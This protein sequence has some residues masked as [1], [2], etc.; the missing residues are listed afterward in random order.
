MDLTE[1]VK[2]NVDLLREV[3]TD[4]AKPGVKQ[5]GRS[6]DAI[7]GLGNTVLWPILLVN[8]KSRMALENNLEKYRK[9][10]ES[11][12]EEKVVRVS[13]E[14]GVPIAEK[15]SYVEDPDLSEMYLELL[16]KASKS[17]SANQ[18]HPSFVNTINNL[19]P[20]EALILD[21]IKD[22]KDIPIV[23][24]RL[25]KDGEN[26]FIAL[27]D[28]VVLLKSKKK[29]S[30]PQNMAVYMSNLESLGVVQIHRDSWL[31]DEKCYKPLY[32][33]GEATFAV[34]KP[35]YPDRTLDFGKGLISITD[36]GKMFIKACSCQP[37]S[38]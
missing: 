10:L 36:Y 9:K 35:K 2:A 16:A 34:F 31:T 20:D 12:P 25:K 23:S 27:N 4:L 30:F 8:E 1:I 14:V 17:D 7:L 6:L 24:L 21:A 26:G 15:I 19:S 32:L 33:T 18:A 29:L 13:P 11:T 37:E 38:E 22:F 3:Y 5:V 28:L